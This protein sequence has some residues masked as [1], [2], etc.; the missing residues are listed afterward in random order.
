MIGFVVAMSS[1]LDT[2]KANG[3]LDDGSG[4]PHIAIKSDGYW[5]CTCYPP[6]V[7]YTRNHRY[8]KLRIL[9]IS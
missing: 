7:F 8:A 5:E 2:A 9:P 3:Y 6:P 4:K 1:L